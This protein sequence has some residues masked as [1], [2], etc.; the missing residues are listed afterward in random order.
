[1]RLNLYANLKLLCIPVLLLFCSSLSYSQT[2]KGT[3]TDAVTGEPLTGAN[4]TLSPPS[5]KK[6]TV[7]LDGTYTFRNIKTGTYELEIRYVSYQSL[8][9]TV[10]ISDNAVNKMNFTLHS[11]VN[12]LAGVSIQSAVTSGDGQA[13]S[14]EKNSDQLVNIL[15]AKTIQLLPDI[16]VANIMQRVPGVII[17][18]SN[19]GEGRYPVIRGMDK[20]YNTTLVNGIKIPSPDNNSRYVPLDLFPAELLERLEVSKSL[21]PSMEGD[22]IGGTINLVMKDAP[23]QLMVLANASA[24][25]STIL[26]DQPFMGFDHSV[27]SKKSPAE[28][29]GPDYSAT[30]KDFTTGN[31]SYDKVNNPVN[32]TFGLTIGDR[33]G[34][35]KQL[36]AI[37]SVSYQDIYRGTNSSYFFP[38]IQPNLNN[39]PVFSDIFL[40]QYSTESKRLGLYNN[41]D[42][43]IKP[44]QKI[45][46]FNMYLR[47]DDY[48]SR[49]TV[50]SVLAISRT[51]PGNGNVNIENRS[52]WQIQ[53]IFNSTLKGTHQLSDRFKADWSAVFSAAKNQVPDYAVYSTQHQVTTNPATGA[54]TETAP[55]LTTMTRIWSHN[56]DKDASFYGNLTYTPEIF[57]RKAEFKAGGLYR[58]KDRDNY[59]NEYDLVA[60]LSANSNQQ[61]FTGINNAQYVFKGSDGGKTG[62]FN[63]NTYAV[64]EDISAGYLQGKI[65]LTDKLEALGGVRVE[66]TY[67][68]YETVQ[69]NTVAGKSGTIHYNDILPSLQFKYSLDQK[70]A[71]RLD[72]YKA[73]SRPGYFELVPTLVTGEY[74][75]EAGNYNL[76]RS[77]ANNFDFRYELFP[78]GADQLLIG[79]FYKQIFDPIELGVQKVNG[80][81]A[82]QVLEPFNFGTAKNFGAEVAVTRYFGQFGVSANYTYTHSRITTDKL[83]YFRD[84]NGNI[85]NETRSQ[86]RPLQGQAD[87]AG[88]LSFIY[89]APKSGLD[90]QI[91]YV[92]TGERIVVLSPYYGLDYWQRPFSQLDF[93]LEKR[94][95]QRLSV[96]TKITNITNSAT[97]VYI[98][99][100]NNFL[101]GRDLLPQQE[102]ADKILVQ[103]T[104]YKPSFLVGLRYKFN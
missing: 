101:S 80:T 6:E 102:E 73:I 48:Q 71:F 84:A 64:D 26:S 92:Y 69:P 65:L 24:G 85:T 13:R 2:L 62:E 41:V 61:P 42:F 33:F 82:S 100:P 20:R 75:N 99:Q 68:H 70:Q 60:A 11:L 55:F 30:G 91:A 34:A 15:S 95:R 22:A 50:D 45:T 104:F 10:H 51:G 25:Y 94:I 21:T 63:A 38:N 52:T 58:H 56:T 67:D 87:H 53:Q 89:K 72:Y 54:V 1:M 27:I 19:N 97:K 29:H 66:H 40:R 79:T 103:N 14:L 74:Y 16:T 18:R 76:N 77:R 90:L 12:E 31:L 83:Y 81:G 88:N 3:V 46:W 44:G 4:I 17:D 96:Y 86:S 47:T 7:L 23:Q 36:G 9:Q 35:K 28:I 43:L 49:N 32:K 37:F 39:T 98:K 5:G 8:K 78:G 57:G 93:S 59:Y